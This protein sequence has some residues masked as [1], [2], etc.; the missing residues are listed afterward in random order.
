MIIQTQKELKIIQECGKRLAAIL[1]ELKRTVKPGISTGFLDKRAEQLIREAGGMP[2]FKG[3]TTHGSRGAYPA[4]VCVSLN[5]EIVH[6]I[7]Q[8]NRI[9]QEGDCVS[10]DIGMR[11]PASSGLITDTALTVSVGNVSSKAEKLIHATKEA[12]TKGISAARA[13]NTIGDIGYAIQAHLEKN[14]FGVI[15]ELV[16]HGV[17]IKLH[18]D[19]YVPNYGKKHEGKILKEGMVLALEPMA[20]IGSPDIVL[21]SDGWTYKT[22]D[23]S[24]SAHFEHTIV[25]Q[26]N[27]AVV[28]TK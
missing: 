26:K 20:T 6:G 10:L 25:I 16:G 24:L 4:S 1:D 9:I 8:K 7:P 5:D 28:L 14:G 17:G 23:G 15:R 22:K 19:P 21:A 2:V 27:R 13:E 18:E 11:Y 12:L 3:Y